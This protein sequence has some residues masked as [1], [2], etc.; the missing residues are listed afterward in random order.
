MSIESLEVPG[1]DV[2][3]PAA[4]P[5]PLTEVAEALPFALVSVLE[6][7]YLSPFAVDGWRLEQRADDL[8]RPL[9]RQ[10]VA[11]GRPAQ[12]GAWREPCPTF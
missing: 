4:G 6:R 3:A 7:R 12:P 10:V 11:L 2:P 5:L 9:L 1:A 8:A